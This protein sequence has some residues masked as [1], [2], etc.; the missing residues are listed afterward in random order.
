[1]SCSGLVC[2]IFFLYCFVKNFSFF[3][4]LNSSEVKIIFERLII[5][6]KRDYDI[7]GGLLASK[8]KITVYL[9]IITNFVF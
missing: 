9:H 6:L 5:F 1:M 8:D 3:F 7:Y 4:F 2:P